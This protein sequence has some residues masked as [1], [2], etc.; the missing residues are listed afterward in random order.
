MEIITNVCA[1]WGRFGS[2]VAL[3]LL[4]HYCPRVTNMLVVV[5]DG[6]FSG[7]HTCVKPT[8]PPTNY[9]PTYTLPPPKLYKHSCQTLANDEQ[10]SF[11]VKV[12]RYEASF[13]QYVFVLRRKTG[14]K[15]PIFLIS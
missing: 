6:P 4:V 1:G 14:E 11:N 10:H 9:I 7:T 13:K 3:Y 2:G 15:K 5:N 12:S 8:I